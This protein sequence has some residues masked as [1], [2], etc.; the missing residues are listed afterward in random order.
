MNILVIDTSKPEVWVA[1]LRDGDI[2]AEEAWA[3]D[4]QLGTKLLVAIQAVTQGK[5]PQR[6]AVHQGPGH[7]MAL[8]TGLVT[9]HLLVQAW[10]V[11]LVVVTGDT[12][13]E[14]A[15]QARAGQPVRSVTPTY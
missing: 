4:K 3:G 10:A 15:Q 11:E 14:M 8:R 12:K 2:V 6:I 1:L 13:T 9:A 5:R 7:F